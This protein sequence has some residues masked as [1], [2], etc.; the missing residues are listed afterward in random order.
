MDVDQK[1]DLLLY[2]IVVKEVS[3]IYVSK[4]IN[5]GLFVDIC[6]IFMI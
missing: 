1:K 6:I 3:M 4:Y 2:V 5:Y